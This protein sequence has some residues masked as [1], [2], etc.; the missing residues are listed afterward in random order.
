MVLK[1]ANDISFLRQ[2]KEMINQYK[3]IGRY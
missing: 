3:I 1:S 2:M